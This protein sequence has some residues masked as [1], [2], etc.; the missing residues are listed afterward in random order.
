MHAGTT[1]DKAGIVRAALAKFNSGSPD[2]RFVADELRDADRDV[3]VV[4]R[5]EDRHQGSPAREVR[6]ALLWEFDDDHL[7]RITRFASKET[8]LDAARSRQDCLR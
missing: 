7:A 3:L 5:V 4:G 6:I 8:A 1:G 2:F